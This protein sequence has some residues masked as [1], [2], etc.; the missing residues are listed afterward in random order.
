MSSCSGMAV[1]GKPARAGRLFARPRRLL[2]TGASSSSPPA[3]TSMTSRGMLL[4]EIIARLVR[5]DI[6]VGELVERLRHRRD[7]IGRSLH[8]ADRSSR[9]SRRSAVD[10]RR[11]ELGE[12]ELVATDCPLAVPARRSRSPAF[13]AS[14]MLSAANGSGCAGY[15]FGSGI[16]RPNASRASAPATGPCTRPVGGGGAGTWVIADFVTGQASARNRRGST[17]AS[18]SAKNR[19]RHRLSLGGPRFRRHRL[20]ARSDR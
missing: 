8:L 13:S 16:S 11:D 20:C 12:V 1:V 17:P 5:R 2:S 3:S 18:R 7:Q 15:G 19:R 14:A 4:D 10:Q 6:L 9:P